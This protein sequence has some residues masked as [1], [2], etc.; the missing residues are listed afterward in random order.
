MARAEP[1]L[2]SPWVDSSPDAAA[3]ASGLALLL[4]PRVAQEARKNRHPL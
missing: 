3:M 1:C 2:F 4:S